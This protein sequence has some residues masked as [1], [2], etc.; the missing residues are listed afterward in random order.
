MSSKSASTHR[1]AREESEPNTE[2]KSHHQHYHHNAD[3]SRFCNSVGPKK[4]GSPHPCTESP[5]GPHPQSTHFDHL[6]QQEDFFAS[7]AASFGGSSHDAGYMSENDLHELEAQ[8]HEP[9]S[10]YTCRHLGYF[11]HDC[12]MASHYD[13]QLTIEEDPNEQNSPPQSEIQR[14][15]TNPTTENGIQVSSNEFEEMQTYSPTTEIWTLHES[16]DERIRLGLPGGQ[17]IPSN[18]FYYDEDLDIEAR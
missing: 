10:Q 3:L 9:S 18:I 13:N 16:R 6:P 11:S 2:S 5:A 12:V 14:V 15:T 8:T 17:E 4:E 1:Q 7:N